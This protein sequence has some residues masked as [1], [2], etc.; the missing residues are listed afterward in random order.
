MNTTAS[1]SES[2]SESASAPVASHEAPATVLWSTKS[3]KQ[4][5][6]RV[7]KAVEAIVNDKVFSDMKPIAAVFDIDETLLLNHVDDESDKFRKNPAVF[8][9]VMKLKDMGVALFAVTARSED[10]AGHVY[11]Q[12]QLEKL[13]YPKFEEIYM[14]P[15]AREVEGTASAF[16]QDARAM[17]N[18]TH[19]VV[20]NVGDQ[21]SDMM[22]C[23]PAVPHAVE[24]W[25]NKNFEKNR[26]YA[27]AVHGDPAVLSI[28]LPNRYHVS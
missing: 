21:S 11:A 27:L 6:G 1:A 10:P 28:K 19:N 14:F 17:I 23:P 26:T 25:C 3:T 22:L 5:M 24:S 9:A 2:A 8:D 20:L 4:A 13:G 7:V 18:R 16:K 15:E 12:M